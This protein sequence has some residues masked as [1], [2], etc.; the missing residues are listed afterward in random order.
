MSLNR[1]QRE[2]FMASHIC[3][4]YNLLHVLPGIGQSQLSGL[5]L[6]SFYNGVKRNQLQLPEP[7]VN[8]SKFCDSCGVVYIAG[9][10][11]DMKV[12]EAENDGVGA[13]SLVYTCRNCGKHKHFQI[14]VK[15]REPTP[16]PAE[17]FVAKWPAKKDESKVKKLTGKER[18]KKRKLDSLSSM[19]SRKREEE[20]SKKKLSLSLDDFLQK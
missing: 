9:V 19:L 2:K 6:K 17:A 20:E 4:K 3:H 15:I 11:L 18:A 7:L 13:K 10:N 12:Q 1:Q 14:S 5:Y 8:G 16:K